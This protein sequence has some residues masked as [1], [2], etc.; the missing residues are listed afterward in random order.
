MGKGNIIG[1]ANEPTANVASGVWSMR[2]Q[3]AAVRGNVW[4]TVAVTIDF[5]ISPAVSGKTS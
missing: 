2:E 3:Y 5:T 1:K 4:P